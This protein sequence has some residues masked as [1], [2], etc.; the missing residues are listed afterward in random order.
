MQIIKQITYLLWV[1][2]LY[3]VLMIR[4]CMLK[5][6][7]AKIL[8]NQTKS[9]HYNNNDSYLL[10]NGK[11]ESKFKAKPDPLIIE[12]RLCIGNLRAQWTTSES[13]KNRIIW[14][15]L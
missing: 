3:K 5:K 10:I 1:I 9:L 7:I 13:E 6:Y 2:D 8:L 12:K 14:K 4:F 11:Q 15:Y